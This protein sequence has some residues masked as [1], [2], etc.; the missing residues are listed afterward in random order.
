[1]TT[2]PTVTPAE[3]EQYHVDPAN[4]PDRTDDGD[5]DTFRH[6][7]KVGDLERAIFDGIP[8]I[9]LCGKKWLPTKDHTKFPTCPECEKIW[10]SLPAE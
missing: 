8:C 3:I 2:T 5:H 7:V 10:E 9:A 1:M 4:L 6:Y